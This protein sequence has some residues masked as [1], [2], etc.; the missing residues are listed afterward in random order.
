M[1]HTPLC[2]KDCETEHHEVVNALQALAP[3]FSSVTA[4]VFSPLRATRGYSKEDFKKQIQKLLDNGWKRDEDVP[5]PSENLKLPLLLLSSMFGKIEAVDW[6]INEEHF[7]V[8]I[9]SSWTNET[10]LHLVVRHLYLAL[11]PS[12]SRLE[13]MSVTEKVSTFEKVVSLL[14][15][16]DVSLL[17][18]KDGLN[19][20]TPFHIL[21]RL[22]VNAS[23]DAGDPGA[24]DLC[25][26]Y[27]CKS[28]DVLL[29]LLKAEEESRLRKKDITNIICAKNGDG[30]TVMHILARDAR[31][32][33]QLLKFLV[34]TLL[35]STSSLKI[36][37]A[38]NVTAM[39]IVIE[40]NP[41][42]AKD[43]LTESEL[44]EDQSMRD[45][46]NG[47]ISYNINFEQQIRS[48]LGPA[49]VTLGI[50]WGACWPSIVKEER[51]SLY[52]R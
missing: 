43:L 50:V 11:S 15:E 32:G 25:L 4:A 1:I 48:Y 51:G 3:R 6:L 39:D 13:N 8:S 44:E 49:F 5:E 30:D 41:L 10:A 2:P 37:N 22:L 38:R 17:W 46:L 19:R 20:D 9:R 21:S 29:K 18:A 42:H 47:G 12:G 40:R 26:S 24:N 36:Q 34:K 27:H 28:F 23:L 31:R 35:G 33:F 7:E 16:K 52:P 45:Q 14:V